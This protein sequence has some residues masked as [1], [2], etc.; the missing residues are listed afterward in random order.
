MVGCYRWVHAWTPPSE[1]GQGWGEF[2][3]GGVRVFLVPGKIGF[4]GA[5]CDILG[6]GEAMAGC[7]ED[8]ATAGGRGFNEAYSGAMDRTGQDSWLLQCVFYPI[9]VLY[10]TGR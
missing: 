6:D 5:G 10:C 4:V 8:V 2:N 7:R 1:G 3:D 9:T